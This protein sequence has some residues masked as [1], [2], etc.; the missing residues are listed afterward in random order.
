[1]RLVF[2]FI[3]SGEQIFIGEIEMSAKNR[4]MV[5]IRTDHH[6]VYGDPEEQWISRASACGFLLH[7][8]LADMP[9]K[10]VLEK[11]IE[12]LLWDLCKS[13]RWSKWDFRSTWYLKEVAAPVDH[14]ASAEIRDLDRAEAM[15]RPDVPILSNVA[16]DDAEVDRMIQEMK[17][18]G[19]AMMAKR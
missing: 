15:Q 17:A 13:W 6:D 19:E 10:T 12:S 1:M 4:Q 9:L 5:L 18:R 8:E 3:N 7:Q 11:Q 14:D 16:I 2:L